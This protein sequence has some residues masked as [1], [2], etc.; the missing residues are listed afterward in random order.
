MKF[1]FRARFQIRAL[2]MRDEELFL[3]NRTETDISSYLVRAQA[4]FEGHSFLNGR[5]TYEDNSGRRNF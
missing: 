4:S 2:S 3:G 5:Y 1:D